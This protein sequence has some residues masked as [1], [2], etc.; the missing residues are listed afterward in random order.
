MEE[1]QTV[2]HT[3]TPWRV[4]QMYRTLPTG[5]PLSRYEIAPVYDSDL[6]LAQ[7]PGD[8]SEDYANALHIAR[9]VNA[10]DDLLAACEALCE[11]AYRIM[12]DDLPLLPTPMAEAIRD[13]RAAIAKATP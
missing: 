12:A 9:C 7:V 10:H 2:Q 3:P 1:T 5:E 8:T 13:A 6:V 11:G 4:L